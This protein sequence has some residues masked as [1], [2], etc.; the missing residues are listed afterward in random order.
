MR[1]NCLNNFYFHTPIIWHPIN[2]HANMYSTVHISSF[3]WDSGELIIAVII[4]IKT[5]KMEI[6]GGT[7]GRGIIK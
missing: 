3:F 7:S 2:P 4:K 1:C 6:L 5:K